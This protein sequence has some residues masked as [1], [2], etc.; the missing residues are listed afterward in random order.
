MRWTS[1]RD[2]LDRIG[3]PYAVTLRGLLLITIPSLAPTVVFD[4]A[5]NGGSMLT[6][7]LVGLAGTAVGGVVYLG[8]GRMLLPE[9]PRKP[10]PATALGVFF[11]AGIVRGATIAILSVNLGVSADY[12]WAYRLTGGAALG[13]CW[14]ALAAIIVDAW[15]RHHDALADLHAR[16]E[17]ARAQRA[18]AEERLRRTRERI[19]DT[20]L[21]Q[22]STIV[23]LLTSAMQAGRDPATARSLATV[24]HATVTDVVRPLSHAL[25]G[26]ESAAPSDPPRIPLNVRS[27]RWV[28]SISV[29]ALRMDPYHPVLTAAVITPSAIPGAIRIFGVVVGLMGATSIGIIAWVILRIARRRHARHAALIGPWSWLP[30]ALTYVAVGVAVATVP[31]TASYLTGGSFWAGWTQGGQTLLILTPLAALGAAIFAAEDRRFAIA[32]RAREAA[33]TQAEWSSHRVQQES[34]AAAHVLARELHG[35]VQSELTAAAL[36]L[37]TWA[38]QPDSQSMDEVLDQVMAA[39]ERVN[40]L[41][42]E[43]FQPP[44]IDPEQAMAGVIAVWSGLVD[45]SLDVHA[46]ARGQLARDV[47]ASET[48]IEIVREC[49]GNAVSH[50]R[51]SSISVD[52]RLASP[53]RVEIAV[54]D[55][56]R[57]LIEHAPHGLGSRMLD[58]LCLEWHRA[59]V[60]SGTGSRVVALI[61]VDA[62]RGLPTDDAEVIGA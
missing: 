21:T 59:P 37:E 48:A 1:A 40:R 9:R 16:Q 34:W 56:G 28:R 12:Q 50:G 39:V 20:L 29:D 6:W 55:D 26:T 27:R 60:S 17:V 13:M 58:Q 30:A 42:A 31:M 10:R 15:T 4:R 11:L 14:F 23:T 5:L 54:V 8:L 46:D 38:R 22:M 36:R 45:V 19:R 2:V 7:A 52:V 49:V 18:D 41:A 35:G 61:A 24:M 33:V 53:R 44:P 62:G 51:A 25:I 3:G 47:A 43:E 57:G 32:E